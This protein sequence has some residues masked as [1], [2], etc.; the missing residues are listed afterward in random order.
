MH[1]MNKSLF[2]SFFEVIRH[3]MDKETAMEYV[4][5]LERYH[6]AGWTVIYDDWK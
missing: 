6:D 4:V 5:M 1:I 2:E 3:K